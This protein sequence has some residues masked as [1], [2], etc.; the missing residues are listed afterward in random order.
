MRRKW[1]LALALAT[2][3]LSA[4]VV[5][6]S[7]G[8]EG[9]PLSSGVTSISKAFLALMTPAQQ[10]ATYI[11]SAKC[12]NP[13]CHGA[14]DHA[15]NYQTWL[16]TM[17]AKNN[18]GCENC[19]GP[20]SVHAANPT[21]AGSILQLPQMQSTVVCAQCHGP[22]YGDWS[23]SLHAQV[24][25]VPLQQSA[26][27]QKGSRCFVCHSGLVRTEYTEN[28]VDVSTLTNTQ[29][30][31]ALSDTL[32]IVPN[33]AGCVTCH[34]PHQLTGN[35]DADGADVQ[36]YHQVTNNDTT[37][38]GPSTAASSFTLYNQVC[39]ECH[40]DRGADGSDAA[41]INGTSRPN[42]HASNQMNML[43]GEGGS[44]LPTA[45]IT[46]T[47]THATI[48][49]QCSH[50]HMGAASHAFVPN[51][52][53]GCQPCHTASDAA[54]RV[55]ALQ[56]EIVNDLYALRTRMQTYATA[57]LGGPDCWDYTSNIPS[58]EVPPDQSLV[59]IQLMRAR[60]NYYF[61][62]EDAS[63]GVH[64]SAYTRYLISTANTNM[65]VIQPGG[66]PVRSSSL[67]FKTKEQI[68]KND[69]VRARKLGGD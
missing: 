38:I 21:V 4:L 67:D 46:R 18:V 32:N 53:T 1:I 54:S 44:E 35:I 29:I 60:E 30:A 33:T 42:M 64:N 11:G 23:A 24:V 43:L 31:R 57:N 58:P 48:V 9:G 17:H 55:G 47:T 8:G 50:C 15:A 5:L 10:K 28:G 62:L 49:G 36:L 12:G 20:G 65:D 39:G 37:A 41:L 19:H 66:A 16:Q 51:Y 25:T 69:L 14:T 13:N 2:P 68:L 7:C 45:P 63:E 34:D 27:T 40:N 61:V 3:C 6:E 22:I 26:G 56:L 59:P 52:D